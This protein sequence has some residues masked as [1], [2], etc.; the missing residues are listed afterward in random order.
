AR[1]SIEEPLHVLV[2]ERVPGE[3]R[4]KARELVAIGKVSVNEQVRRFDEG[5]VLTKLFDRDAAITEYPLLAVDIGDGARGRRGVH[6]RRIERDEPGFRSQLRDV[7]GLLVLGSY[8]D[9]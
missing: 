7:D 8:D 5:R 9:R 4:R 2:D 6:E 3:Q 1:V